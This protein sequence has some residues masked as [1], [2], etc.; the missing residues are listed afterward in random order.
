MN[1]RLDKI[2][3]D[4]NCKTEEEIYNKGLEEKLK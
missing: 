2:Y 1:S 3:N 4:I